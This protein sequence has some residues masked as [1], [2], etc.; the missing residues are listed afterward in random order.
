MSKI[1][2][3][4]DVYCPLILRLLARK[5]RGRPLT[6]LEIADASGLPVTTVEAIS[7]SVD[8]SGIDVPS[9]RAFMKGV[10]IDLASR[11]DVRRIRMYL[12]TSP[13]DP[14]RRFPY[15]RKSPEW[16][17]RYLPMLEELG[18]R[19]RANR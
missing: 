18:R 5:R 2:E 14:R 19:V 7:W 4:M 11:D 3:R 12:R 9:A 6:T 8:W 17:T 16:K 15:L 10:G 13:K 1:W